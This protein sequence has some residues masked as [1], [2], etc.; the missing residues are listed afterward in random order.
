MKKARWVGGLVL[1]GAI[2]LSACGSGD[3]PLGTPSGTP[4]PLGSGGSQLNSAQKRVLERW[5]AE[6]AAQEESDICWRRTRVRGAGEA[7]STCPSGERDGALCYPKCA[8]NY[9]G[10]GPVCW[11]RCKSGYI[12]D[13]AFCR[14]NVHIVE[15]KHYGRGAG[16]ASW[17]KSKCSKE[18]G[19]CEL[20][21]AMYY[22]KCR[23]GYEAVGC[24]LCRER[25]C[26]SG[27]TDDGALC[28]KDAHIYAKH[29]YGRGVGDPMSCASGLEQSGAL[30]YP[31]CGND[32]TGVGPVCW[33]NCPKNQ[34]ID[35]GAICGKSVAQCT[36]AI[37]DMVLA[38][39]EL[40][41]NI[42]SAVL[43][44]GS[45]S[46]VKSTLKSMLVSALE[47]AGKWAVQQILHESQVFR[48]LSAKINRLIIEPVTKELGSDVVTVIADAA[49]ENLL[50]AML[51][52]DDPDLLDVFS[53]IDPTGVAAVIDAFYHPTCVNDRL[54]NL[55]AFVDAKQPTNLAR[56]RPSTQSST[57]S[58]GL[59]SFATDTNPTGA[60]T[61]TNAETQPWWQVDLG[62]ESWIG[63]VAVHRVAEGGVV[64]ELRVSLLDTQR[65]LISSQI[66]SGSAGDLAETTFTAPARYVKVERLSA[67]VLSLR[68]VEVHEHPLKTTFES[69]GFL[70]LAHGLPSSQSST[71][72]GDE[73][74]LG[75]DG[76][77][78]TTSV[79]KQ[80]AGA[81]WQVDLGAEERIENVV[82]DGDLTDF[83]IVLLDERTRTVSRTPITG[84]LTGA[85]AYTLHSRARYVR[86][87]LRGSGVIRIAELAVHAVRPNMALAKSARQSSHLSLGTTAARAVDGKRDSDPSVTQLNDYRPYWEVDLGRDRD[88]SRVRIHTGTAKLPPFTVS[89]LTE[90]SRCLIVSGKR[91]CVPERREVVSVPA[92]GQNPLVGI[93]GTGRLVRIELNTPG[94]LRLNEVEVF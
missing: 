52:D 60:A 47:Q 70:N 22:P 83:D 74:E 4:P 93:A 49:A 76:D 55:N 21:G 10:V 19:S 12:D 64:P 48:D 46:V 68:E 26:P 87:E 38:P 45:L 58:G 44:G 25:R 37:S 42:V 77:P 71:A 50:I 84:R 82:I 80:E 8:S 90:Q 17:D 2:G 78:T 15:K 39:I 30:C 85:A 32:Y 36:L 53:E 61:R 7:L 28:R 51:I 91:I 57:A 89:V 66:L 88:V 1:T 34:P 81:F 75:N 11:A 33:G 14:K 59:S 13:G 94:Q 69:S 20:Y 31:R 67:G 27:Y 35:C 72:N 6:V 56:N 62:S 29:S 79:T 24:C 5:A 65:R 18:H 3:E 40:V 9:D 41:Q 63:R 16:Y 92:S 54:P 73:A 23:A 86:V 43:S